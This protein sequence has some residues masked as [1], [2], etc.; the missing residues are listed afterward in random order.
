MFSLSAS[1]PEAPPRPGRSPVRTERSSYWEPKPLDAGVL[2]RLEPLWHAGT[3]A[4]N[5]A[6]TRP[7]NRRYCVAGCGAY[8]EG[9]G[10]TQANLE[11]VHL[12]CG[13][14][15]AD[16]DQDAGLT[17]NLTGDSR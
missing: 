10:V 16:A 9:K 3:V 13:E 8:V 17:L 15:P 1:R 14:T 12:R 7:P 2:A 6:D 4:L 5:R 11:T